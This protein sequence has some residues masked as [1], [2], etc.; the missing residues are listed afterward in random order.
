M[1]VLEAGNKGVG[2]DVCEEGSES[3]E[4]EEFEGEHDGG[5]ITRFLNLSEREI[6]RGECE[7]SW[8]FQAVWKGR[9]R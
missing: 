1:A 6:E 3:G 5:D 9:L 4:D 8:S 7:S 2:K